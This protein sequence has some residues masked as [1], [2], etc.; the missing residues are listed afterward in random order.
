MFVLLNVMQLY[1]QNITYFMRLILTITY[2]ADL[3]LT[4]KNPLYPASKRAK[5]YT[6]VNNSIV[7]L[8]VVVAAS[9]TT[10]H[11]HDVFRVG[12]PECVRMF[13]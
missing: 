13:R 4:I 11:L 1:E 2:S 3:I 7:F 10:T 5:V 9:C 12:S 6:I 8:M